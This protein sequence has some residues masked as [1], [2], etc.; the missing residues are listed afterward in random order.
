MNNEVI[1]FSR[2][3]CKNCYKCIRSCPVKAIRMKNDQA[4]INDEMCIKCGTC[5]IVCPQNAK[6]VKND[7]PKVKDLIMK[8]NDV[9]VSLAPSFAGAFLF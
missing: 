8:N 3:N 9:V 4:E 7:V 5:L 1:N 2:A 6:T